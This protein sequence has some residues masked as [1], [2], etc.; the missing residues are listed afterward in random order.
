MHTSYPTL[1]EAADQIVAIGRKMYEK[2]FVASNDGNISVRLGENEVLMTPTGVSKG[3][4]TPD[5]LIRLTLDGDILGGTLRASSETAMHLRIYRENDA[6][7][8]ITHAHCPAATSFA[9]ARIPLDVP[10]YPESLVITGP[11]PVAPYAT[12]GTQE[13]P[14]SVAPFC[15]RYFAVLLANHGPVTW[16]SSLQEAYFRLESLESFAKIYMYARFLLGKAEALTPAELE[17]LAHTTGRN[18]DFLR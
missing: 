10:V 2:G 18:S 12:P 7:M 13:V 14:D 3:A 16:G 6:I 11:V 9:I 1:S 17:K 15:R 4:L 8:A 5:M